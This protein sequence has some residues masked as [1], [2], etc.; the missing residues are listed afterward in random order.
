MYNKHSS[1]KVLENMEKPDI[2]QEIA[3][4]A[5][6]FFNYLSRGVLLTII[7]RKKEKFFKKNVKCTV[8]S[9]AFFSLSLLEDIPDCCQHILILPITTYRI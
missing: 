4:L 3:L 1:V 2:F 8:T 9:S 7:F 5:R 6:V